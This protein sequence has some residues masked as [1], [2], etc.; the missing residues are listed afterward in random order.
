[1]S[2]ALH[3]AAQTNSRPAASQT[4]S[5]PRPAASQTS[6]GPRPA[7]APG[8]RRPQATRKGWPYYRRPLH[9]RHERIA[10]SR[11]TPCG[12]PVGVGGLWAWVA[13]GRGWPV[14]VWRGLW[15]WVACGRGWPVGVGGLWAWVACGRGWP[16]GVGGR[17]GVG[18]GLG[19]PVAVWPR[20]WTRTARLPRRG[21]ESVGLWLA[22]WLHFAP[23]AIGNWIWKV[24]PSPGM[25]L[26]ATQM[27]PCMASTRRREM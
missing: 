20:S 17:V 3:L 13:C 16:V 15:A 10:Y 27:V 5:G 22:V 21:L 7:A 1:M 25:P 9:Q 8:Q 24:V 14:A 2:E 26:L 23:T 11:A 4:S 19:M 6:G 18:G 12:W